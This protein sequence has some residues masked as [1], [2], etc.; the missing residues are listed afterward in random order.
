MVD[1]VTVAGPTDPGG[2][3]TV[4]EVGP[5]VVMVARFPPTVT[6][7]VSKFVPVM[8]TP[9]LPESGPFAGD[10]PVIVGGGTK[11][12]TPEPVPVPPA[13][14]TETGAV[15]AAPGGVVAVNLVGDV[16]WTLVAGAL[17]NS[18]AVAPVNPCPLMVTGVPPTVGPFPDVTDVTTGTQENAVGLLQV[19]PVVTTETETLS[20]HTGVLT[21]SFV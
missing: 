7:A 15:P 16:T 10:T 4:S 19:P 11:L 20:V 21:D 8:T 12:N 2:T 3:V 9:L 14:V 17:P 6:V 1:T 13:V 5:G 18:T